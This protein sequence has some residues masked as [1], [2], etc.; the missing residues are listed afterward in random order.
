MQGALLDTADVPTRN[1]GLGANQKSKA[2]HSRL[3]WADYQSPF[4]KNVSELPQYRTT[5]NDSRI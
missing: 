1:T 4:Q 2:K 3:Q 5:C